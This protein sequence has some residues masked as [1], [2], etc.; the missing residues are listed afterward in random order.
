MLRFLILLISSS[1]VF[2]S[3]AAQGLTSRV[4]I[5]SL[6]V[7][8][9]ADSF[10]SAMS[11]DGSIIAFE[12][13]ADN[14]VDGDTNQAWD[15]FLKNNILGSIF[16]VSLPQG[17]AQAN[18][19][20]WSP[21][22]SGDGRYLV[23]VSQASN[24]VQ[25]DLNGRWDVFLLDRVSGGTQIISRSSSGVQGNGDCNR[26]VV[27]GDG[28]YVAFDSMA[29]NLVANDTNQASDVFVYDRQLNTTARVSIGSAGA[30]ANG[31]SGY[32]V[33]SHDGRF[34][35]YDSVATNLTASDTNG[36]YDVF[37]RDRNSSS[38]S[39]VSVSSSGQQG[40]GD[41]LNAAISGDG[42]RVGFESFATNLVAGDTNGY[43]D[44][45]IRTGTTT[46]R[47]SLTTGGLQG[48]RDSYFPV[49]SGDGATI[50]YVSDADNFVQGDDNDAAD[51]FARVGSNTVLVSV[52]TSGT[53]SDGWSSLPSLSAN[54]NLIAF[55]SI[56]TN[57]VDDDSN[58]CIDV[59]MRDRVKSTSKR[60]SF[61]PEG[62]ESN[63]NSYGC[64]LSADGRI[65]AFVSNATNLV[66]GDMNGDADIFAFDTLTQVTRMVSVSTSGEQSNSFSGELFISGNGRSVA[67]G[68]Y[69][70]NLTT[71]PEP[72]AYPDV[73]V[74]DLVTGET[75]LISIGVGGTESN[76]GSWYPSLSHDGRFVSFTSFASN[77]VEGDNN[78][79]S[80]IFVYDIQQ[81]T[82][83]LASTSAAGIPGNAASLYSTL[84]GSG[85]YLAL[86][87]AA[88]NLVL[89]DTNQYADMFVKDLLTGSVVLASISTSGA[90][91]NAGADGL[92]AIDHDGRRVAF[93]SLSDNLVP[94]DTN[95]RED[96]F[97]R[98]IN[99]GVTI[100]VSEST[101]GQ[102]SNGTSRWP[103]LSADGRYVAYHSSADN[104]VP[105]DTNFHQDVFVRSIDNEIT[106]RVSIS[107]G[108]G[109][110][111]SASSGP[112]LSADGSS[113]SFDS[114]ASNLVLADVNGQVDVFL[115]ARE[116]LNLPPAT[117]NIVRGVVESGNLS[118]LVTSDDSRLVMR[119]GITFTTSQAPVEFIVSANLNSPT[120]T[121]LRFAIESSATSPAVSQ[122]IEL[123]DF[124]ANA[125]VLV[126]ARSSTLSDTEVL[127][128][129]AGAMRFIGPAREVRARISYKAAGPVFAYP[130]R[131]RIDR[132]RWLIQ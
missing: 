104:L 56:G 90:H 119:P 98:D 6:S 72:D 71:E 52:S 88:S 69:A 96:V 70:T 4:S 33:I 92:P 50:A 99:G 130:W 112:S 106:S 1:A 48:N 24:I 42:S 81:G 75:K 59:F 51:V 53:S 110:A 61:V 101:A 47:A 124:I 31:S 49:I 121:S 57:V 14:L 76:A 67:F 58:N 83:T 113:V 45:F 32:P 128:A 46:T 25:P 132:V 74:H 129:P 27:S 79:E 68:S 22:L 13:S 5:S 17:G 109:Q 91:A 63:G 11:A 20:S 114:S 16:R 54:G 117:L 95:F 97:V 120:L 127:V 102:Q 78:N 111:N 12:S 15:I 93:H 116:T 126:D 87:S 73:F 94:G 44:V 82:M 37:V 84:C 85:R 107:S 64:R 62:A 38:T 29:S 115:H 8:A 36:A 18:G 60:I 2:A 40:N 7:E 26:A 66:P 9:N 43:F 28:R 41:S 34:V 23:Y 65:V 86:L 108:G 100:R 131:A 118:S 21:S 39:R 19:N 122:R 89:G 10:K 55:P 103:S 123:F 77:L 80:D 30:Q 35:A 125:Y 3:S 105:G